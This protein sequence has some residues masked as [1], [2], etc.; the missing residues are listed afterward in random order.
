MPY[1]ELT[2]IRKEPKYSQKPQNHSNYYDG[3]QDSLNLALHGDE[4]VDKPQQQAYYRE[5]YYNGDERHLISPS[6]TFTLSKRQP[7]R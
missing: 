6:I 2:E 7:L 5:S 1:T 4:A 3:I